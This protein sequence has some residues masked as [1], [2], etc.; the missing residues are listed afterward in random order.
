[1]HWELV[2]NGTKSLF[3]FKLPAGKYYVGDPDE[4]LLTGVLLTTKSLGNG[5]YRDRDSDSYVVICD[6][7]YDD[8]LLN[9]NEG[10]RH[11]FTESRIVAVASENIVKP[12]PE[13]D[14][15]CFNFGQTFIVEVD[16]DYCTLKLMHEGRLVSL[17]PNDPNVEIEETDEQM[18]TRLYAAVGIDY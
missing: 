4:M 1:M 2:S 5:V 9:D 13:L 11:V 16:L 8:F 6:F 10:D 12:L 15:S 18:Y 3:D 14:D 7:E 17:Y